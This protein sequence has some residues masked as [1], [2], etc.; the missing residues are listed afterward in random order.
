MTH[1]HQ[2]LQSQLKA[3]SIDT[4]RPL[5]VHSS[6]KAIGH[7]DGGPQTVLDT[8]CDHLNVEQSN[9]GLLIFPSH[10]W[11]DES[12]PGGVFKV[13][14]E[15]SCVGLLSELFRQRSGVQRSKHPTHSVCA[16]G[17]GAEEYLAL[18]DQAQ[19]PCPPKGCWGELANM[20]AQIAFIGCTLS[21]NT[22]IHS[23]EEKANVPNRLGNPLHLV[24]ESQAYRRQVLMQRHQAPVK[25]VSRHYVKLAP[26][27]YKHGALK[28]FEFG[29][30]ACYLLDAA[31]TQA[32]CLKLLNRDSDLFGDPAPIPNDWF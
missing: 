7:V 14:S 9:P 18:D 22:F 28:Q 20:Q 12:N 2:S 32:I 23:L 8:F 26:A 30:A 29:D 25:D 11:L 17:K 24:I 19:S 13:Q 16:I 27:L 31:K 4:Q 21:S 3:A 6:M 10:S 5:L 1:I 15:P